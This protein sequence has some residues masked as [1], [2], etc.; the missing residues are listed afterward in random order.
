MLFRSLAI[1]PAKADGTV[2][3][4]S[5]VGT[6]AFKLESFEPGVRFVAK[7]NPNYWKEGRGHFDEIQAE[8]IRETAGFLDAPD[9]D[10]TSVWVDEPHLACADLVVDPRLFGDRTN[11]L[12]RR[13]SFG[14]GAPPQDGS[15]SAL[16]FAGCTS[17]HSVDGVA[18][19][20]VGSSAS[21]WCRLWPEVYTAGANCN[22]RKMPTG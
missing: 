7:R 19:G 8:L 14:D 21:A 6:G 10:L 12:D 5:G 16:P 13:L 17:A 15:A 3:W 1:M 11:L 2:D 9:P 22:T 4:Q 20:R 18:G